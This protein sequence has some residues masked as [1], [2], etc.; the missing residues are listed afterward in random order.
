MK[1][2]RFQ[3]NDS[4]RIEEMS[5]PKGSVE[6]QIDQGVHITHIDLAIAVDVGSRPSLDGED[7]IY[8]KI[9][10]ADVDLAIAIGIARE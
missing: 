6:D 10:V 7:G 2:S 8:H 9:D 3:I 4:C 1:T 5:R